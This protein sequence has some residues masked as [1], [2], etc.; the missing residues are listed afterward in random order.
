MYYVYLLRSLK[1]NGFYI[2][3]TSDPKQRLIEHQ[4]G[5]V[6]STKNRR[7]VEMVYLEGYQEQSDA[8]E[9]EKSLKQFGSAY[10]GLLKRIGCR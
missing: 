10:S 4:N 2:G 3:Y 5:N 8:L 7:P 6:D 9:R 1:D